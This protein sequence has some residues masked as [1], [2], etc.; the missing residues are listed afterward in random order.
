MESPARERD[1]LNQGLGPRYG[2]DDAIDTPILRS[3]I[4]VLILTGVLFVIALGAI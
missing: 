2:A 1:P 3:V 4:L